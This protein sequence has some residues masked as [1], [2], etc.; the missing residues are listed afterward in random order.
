[1][2]EQHD[3]AKSDER[4][5]QSA[6]GAPAEGAAVGD[7]FSADEIF[8]RLTATAL[9]E[10]KRTPRQLWFSGLGA[11]LAAGAAF[12]GRM[13]GAAGVGDYQNLAAS[14]LYPL[15]FVIIVIARYQLFTE[16]T[17]TPLTL[18]LTRLATIRSLLR[19]WG[20]VLA[21]NLL[22]AV[23]IGAFLAVGGVLDDEIVAMGN[24]IV[25]H[26]FE[27]PVGSLVARGILAGG[28]VAAMVWLT[29]AVH[30][31]T[32]RVL[33]VYGL[34]L[35]IPVGGLFHVV[36][37]AAEVTFGVVQGLASW[38]QAAGFVVAVGVGNTIGGIVLVALL[39]FGQTSDREL[40]ALA[41]REPLPWREWLVGRTNERDDDAVAP[42]LN[43]ADDDDPDSIRHASS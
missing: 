23:L 11:G 41:H 25:G 12:L 17:L 27:V 2:A 22:G 32:A 20:I 29:H 6:T 9:H 13:A 4:G 19:L 34:M 38:S 18:V 3:G 1:M 36:I 10:F 31:S 30:G 39:N 16:N 5:R 24:E 28:V 40:D 8:Q 7:V 35:L 15:G 37:G 26:A 43:G 14:L 33:V 42:E 21:A